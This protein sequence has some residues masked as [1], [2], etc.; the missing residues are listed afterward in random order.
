MFTVCMVKGCMQKHD[1]DCIYVKSVIRI[2]GDANWMIM[3]W[4]N[5]KMMN[6]QQNLQFGRWEYAS[7]KEI[8]T[9]KWSRLHASLFGYLRDMCY[10]GKLLFA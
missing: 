3:D 5:S 10:I 7:M 8:D 4:P 6:V 2:L 9:W 1:K